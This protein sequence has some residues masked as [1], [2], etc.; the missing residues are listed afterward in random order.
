MTEW[1]EFRKLDKEFEVMKDRIVI[2]GRRMLR[3][4]VIHTRIEYEGIC[5]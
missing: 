1:D 5:W 3:P 4:D 2:D